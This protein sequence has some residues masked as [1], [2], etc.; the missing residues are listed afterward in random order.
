MWNVF[1]D[2]FD[3]VNRVHQQKQRLP[4]LTAFDDENLIDSLKIERIGS[5]RIEG[6]GGHGD[7]TSP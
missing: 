3:L 2:S 5:Q 7:D 6:F 4:V 1:G